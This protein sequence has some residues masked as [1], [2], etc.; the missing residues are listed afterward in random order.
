MSYY[1]EGSFKRAINYYDEAVNDINNGRH[2]I[3]RGKLEIAKQIFEQCR[4][5]HR[6]AQNWIDKTNKKL[7]QI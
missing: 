7:S 6:E 1:S 4:E 5:E 3:A 2:D